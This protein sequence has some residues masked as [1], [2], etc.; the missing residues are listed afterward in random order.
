[1][2]T[3]E[4]KLFKKLAR[5]MGLTIRDHNLLKDGDRL[6]V[7]LS[8]GKDSMI[9]LELLADRIKVFPFNVEMFAVHIVPE[10]IGYEVNLDYL[11]KFA[12]DLAVDLKIVHTKP[13]IQKSDIRLKM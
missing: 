9:M 1:M 10:D 5:K 8:G 7:G 2:R 3:E 4:D 6:L 13:D 11:K 12:V